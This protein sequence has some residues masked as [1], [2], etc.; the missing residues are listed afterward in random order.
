MEEQNCSRKK[1]LSQKTEKEES[2]H[3]TVIITYSGKETVTFLFEKLKMCQKVSTRFIVHDVYIKT[4]I[5]SILCADTLNQ[6]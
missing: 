4:K 1:I 5:L 3:K 6:F 2:H